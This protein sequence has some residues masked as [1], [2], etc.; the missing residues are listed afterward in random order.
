MRWMVLFMA[1][2]VSAT[3]LADT[4]IIAHRG[5]SAHLPEHTMAAYLLAY[6]QGADFLEPDLVLTRDGVPVA[7]HDRTL[8]ATSDVAQVFPGRARDD[9]LHYAIDF[10]LA[11]LERLNFGERVEPETGQARYPDR[12][13][14]GQGRFGIVTLEA[15]V[16]TTRSLNRSTG[17]RVGLYPELKFPSFHRDHGQ[18]IAA[19][20]VAVLDRHALPSDDLPVWIQC[21]EPE[22]L[23]D[24]RDAHGDR[25]TLIQL[26]AEREWAGYEDVDWDAMWAADGLDAVAAYAD[27]VGP[28][29]ARLLE[30][31]DDGVV[32]SVH[33]QAARE[34]GLVVH[35]FTFRRESMPEGVTLEAML[36]LFIH[37]LRVEALF[38]DHPGVAVAVRAQ[39]P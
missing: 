23:R 28:P 20:V 27:G 8:D 14:V 24:L 5:A 11:E 31:T 6:G 33:L 19:A 10:T 15:L 17:R 25:F 37:E 4:R 3:A 34:R 16:E 18:D 38:T 13:P 32:P 21:F 35:P 12:W 26:L 30:R 36:G 22:T 39:A 2:T 9:G 7:L 29:L 1:A